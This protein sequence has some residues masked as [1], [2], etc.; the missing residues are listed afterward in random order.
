MKV[1]QCQDQGQDMKKEVKGS[2]QGHQELNNNQI[3]ETKAVG[4]WK[5][6]MQKKKKGKGKKKF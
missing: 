4:A 3:T 2:C 6:T 1:E 5:H